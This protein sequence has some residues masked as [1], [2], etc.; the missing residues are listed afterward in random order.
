PTFSA[1]FPYATLFRSPS[2]GEPYRPEIVVWADAEGSVLGASQDEFDIELE[3]RIATSFEA[4]TRSPLVGR[5]HTPAR[6]RAETP[7]LAERDR[8]STRLNSSH[9][10]S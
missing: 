4:A 9:V 1:R 2:E 6:L 8:K 5:P 3:A 10:S 7:E